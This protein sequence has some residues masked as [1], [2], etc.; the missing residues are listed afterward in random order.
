MD[1]AAQFS[2]PVKPQL[3]WHCYLLVQRLCSLLQGDINLHSLSDHKGQ[4]RAHIVF[5]FL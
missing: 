5:V 3:F 1:S 4:Q 2:T